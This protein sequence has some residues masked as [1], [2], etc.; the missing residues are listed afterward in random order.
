MTE[1][2]PLVR[3]LVNSTGKHVGWVFWCPGCESHHQYGLGWTFNGDVY[4]P[5]FSPSLLVYQPDAAGKRDK[6]LCHLFVTGGQIKYCSDSPHKLAGK[7]VPMEP[8][9]WDEDDDDDDPDSG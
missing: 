8:P 1:A 6:T 4:K 2:R 9:P 3:K 5:T 7:T